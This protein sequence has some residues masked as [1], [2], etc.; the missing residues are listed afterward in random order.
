MAA[1]V[2]YKPRFIK[3][4]T[5]AAVISLQEVL[6]QGK[7]LIPKA[8]PKREVK[9]KEKEA[10]K[11]KSKAGLRGHVQKKAKGGTGPDPRS[12]SRKYKDTLD[13]VFET[14]ALSV[15]SLKANL[16]HSGKFDE[17]GQ[18]LIIWTIHALNNICLYMFQAF[19]IT[20]PQDKRSS[21][22]RKLITQTELGFIHPTMLPNFP[23]DPGID[24]YYVPTNMI[25]TNGVEFQALA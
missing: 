10:E 6:R 14:V 23:G 5:T 1:L 25:K 21:Y 13:K 12:E 20:G 22:H 9:T 8:S 11:Q 16:R 15:G 18:A 17:Q 7:D 19:P 4:H 2:R 24:K 3:D